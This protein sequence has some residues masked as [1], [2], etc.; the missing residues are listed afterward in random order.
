MKTEANN[1]KREAPA[2]RFST[3]HGDV[4][5]IGQDG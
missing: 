3:G 1:P 4:F 2:L 5:R